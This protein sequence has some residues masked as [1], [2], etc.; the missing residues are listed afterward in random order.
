MKRALREPLVHFLLLGVAI[1]AVRGWTHKPTADD[2]EKIVLTEGEIE[3]MAVGFG[4]TWRRP[5]TR[6]EL[7][8]LIRDRVREEVY[9]REAMA[10]GL[11][12]DDTIIRRRLRQKME[13]VTDDVAAQAEPTDEDLIAYLNAHPDSFRVERRFTFA[14]V[15]LNPEK[16]GEHLARDAAELLAILTRDGGTADAST[17]GDRFLLDQR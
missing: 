12:K 6:E 9:S 2:P 15:Y 4:R 11:D 14:H 5:P 17:L 3:S 7:D 13:F 1:F 8:G 10:L 16:H